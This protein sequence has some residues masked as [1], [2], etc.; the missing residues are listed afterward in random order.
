MD[1]RKQH[2][3]VIAATRQD[4]APHLHVSIGAPTS[5]KDLRDGVRQLR[6]PRAGIPCRPSRRTHPRP[7]Q[8]FFERATRPGAVTVTLMT[9]DSFNN[10][11]EEICHKRD[12]TSVLFCG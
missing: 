1:R 9:S 11:E 7:T 8:Q 2:F 5:P 6:A 4:P 10:C 3:Q 12:K